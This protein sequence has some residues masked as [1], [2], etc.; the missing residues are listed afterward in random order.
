MFRSIF[1]VLFAALGIVPQSQA[2]DYPNKTIRLVAPFAAGAT[3][4]I[5][6]RI[7]AQNLSESLGKP[8]IVENRPGANGLIGSNVVAKAAPDGYSLLLMTPSTLYASPSLYSQMSFDPGKDLVPVSKLGNTDFVLIAGANFPASTLKDLLAMAK[9]EPGKRTMAHKSLTAQLGVEWLKQ[10]AGI[11]INT[12]SYKDASAAF[13]DLTSGQL[14]TLFEPVPSSIAQIRAGKVKALAVAASQRSS[15]LPN[16]PTVIES[17]FPG[18]DTSVEAVIYAPAGTPKE[19][20]AKLHGE[21]LKIVNMPAVRERFAQLGMEA[22]TS[23]PERL[24]EAAKSEPAKWSR[25][26]KNANIPK[27]N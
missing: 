3:L 9:S 14:D 26:I 6:G 24:A 7:V 16:V 27:I 25:I 18:F 11:D 8:V 17:G 4:D 13:V 22:V 12:V 10:I 1:A 2:Q 19:I 20:I 21:I 5:L 15:V 23:T